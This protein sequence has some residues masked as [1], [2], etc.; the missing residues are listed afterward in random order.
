MW[1]LSANDLHNSRNLV[2][3]W[4]SFR[5][6]CFDVYP[7]TTLEQVHNS[8]SVNVGLEIALLPLDTRGQAEADGTFESEVVQKHIKENSW[9]GPCF[10]SLLYRHTGITISPACKGSIC[11]SLP[12]NELWPEAAA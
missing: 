10:K 6:Y 2:H 8:N 12:P 3:W 4:E 7:S 5:R 9:S 11:K 1:A